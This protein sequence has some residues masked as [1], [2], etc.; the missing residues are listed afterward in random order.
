MIALL[1]LPNLA[2]M[3]SEQLLVLVLM[4]PKYLKEFTLAIVSPSTSI[5][6]FAI[7][8][9]TTITLVFRAFDFSSIVLPASFTLCTMLFTSCWDLP[10]SAVSSAYRKF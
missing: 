6:T 10:Y 1:A 7:W 2:L 4:A 5:D 3:S 8:S 9:P